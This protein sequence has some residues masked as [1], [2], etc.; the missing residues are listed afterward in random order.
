MNVRQLM[1]LCTAPALGAQQSAQPPIPIRAL[2]PP[3]AI[4]KETLGSING[5]KQLPDGRVLVN[6]YARNVYLSK[7]NGASGF[8]LERTTI[9]GAAPVKQ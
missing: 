2:A 3:S 8:I 5:I 4:S 1:F 9:V 6:D 7:L